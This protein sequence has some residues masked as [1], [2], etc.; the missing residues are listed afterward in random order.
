MAASTIISDA[1]LGLSGITDTAMRAA[2]TGKTIAEAAATYLDI[3]QLGIAEAY[4]L[5][6]GVVSYAID[7]QSATMSI[8]DADRLVAFLTRM[9]STGGGPVSMRVRL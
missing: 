4:R 9:R 1:I 8:Q 6:R 7:G 2:I 5:K 3:I